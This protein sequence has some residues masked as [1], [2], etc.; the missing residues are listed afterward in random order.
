VVP[1]T[2]AAS[3]TL[4]RMVDVCPVASCRLRSAGESYTPC[5]T[6]ALAKGLADEGISRG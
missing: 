6:D 2:S 3:C 4:A 5:P 1:N